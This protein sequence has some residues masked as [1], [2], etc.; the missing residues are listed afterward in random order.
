MTDKKQNAEE[1]LLDRN[2][3]QGM[4]NARMGDWSYSDA[5][6][7]FKND[8][9]EALSM[10]REEE[11]KKFKNSLKVPS[12]KYTKELI[13]YTEQETAKK[14]FEELEKIVPCGTCKGEHSCYCSIETQ[15]ES[16]HLPNCE[17]KDWCID[18]E[19]LKAKWVKEE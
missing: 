18:I 1:W 4:V 16:K 10:A 14:I 11:R 19:S 2:W 7:R 12:I 6:Q 15:D 13:E 5:E 9:L 17:I 3:I 8:A